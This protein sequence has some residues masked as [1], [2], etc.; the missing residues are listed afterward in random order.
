MKALSMIVLA[1]WAGAASAQT[2][3]P[4]SSE[5]QQAQMLGTW[6]VELERPRAAGT[7]VLEKHATYAGS[8]RGS[9][10]R[11]D[12]KLQVAGDVEDG[13][14]TMEESADGVHIDATWLG[15]VVEGSCGREIRGTRSKDGEGKDARDFVL[16]K[17]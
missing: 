2:A 5:I 8:L 9:L 17:Q 6:R 1:A 3:C 11:G 4:H 12:A 13:E 15:E 16:R 7:L 10:E 14:F